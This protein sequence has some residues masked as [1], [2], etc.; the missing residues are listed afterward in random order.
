[1][2]GDILDM[3]CIFICCFCLKGVFSQCPRNVILP[4]EV[5]LTQDKRHRKG[6]KM[7]WR[8]PA[9]KK[10]NPCFFYF[11]RFILTFYLWII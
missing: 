8:E 5:A 10:G 11:S 6:K 2:V 1:M 7:K 3:S 9:E 4:V